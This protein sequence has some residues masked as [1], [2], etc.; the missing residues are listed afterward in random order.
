MSRK[1]VDISLDLVPSL[2]PEALESCYWELTEDV[3]GADARFQKEEW[4][5]TT[6]LEWGPCG[7]LAMDGDT[8]EGFAQYGP[9]P[10]FPRLQQFRAGKVCMAVYLANC[11]VTRK[12]RGRGLGTTLVRAVA[13]DLVDRGYEAIE[14]LGDRE[15]AGGWILPAEFLG[16]NGFAVV[17]D[18]PRFPLMR[19]E[20]R[21]AV[22]PETAKARA[23]VSM[24]AGAPAPGLA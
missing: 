12:G 13:R 5:S 3:E 22:E 7:K 9:A 17:R 11:Y 6:L 2:P 24:P 4:F 19:L 8:A 14:A 18:D 16:A 1:I 21:T 23:S 15:W 20:L 10:L